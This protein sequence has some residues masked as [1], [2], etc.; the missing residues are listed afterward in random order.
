MDPAMRRES[1]DLIKEAKKDRVI[2]VTT[3]YLDEAEYLADRISILSRGVFQ[4]CGSSH[5]LRKKWGRGYILDITK[6]TEGSDQ[7]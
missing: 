4:S 6:V 7:P 3:N 5:F 1:W 2:L